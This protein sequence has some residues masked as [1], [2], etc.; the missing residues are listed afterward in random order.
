[1]AMSRLT[2]YLRLIMLSGLLLSGGAL[3]DDTPPRPEPGSQRPAAEPQLPTK[4]EPVPD[5]EGFVPDSR[6][7]NMATVDASIPAAP[8]VAVAYG[9]IWLAVLGFV[10][11]TLQ[12]TRKLEQEIADLAERIKAPRR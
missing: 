11:F 1:M 3:A 7:A 10:V 9:F 2:P 5:A 12:R 4:K 8:L 6:P